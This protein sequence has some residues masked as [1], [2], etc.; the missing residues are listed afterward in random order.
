MRYRLRDIPALL[1]SPIGRTQLRGSI[2]MT[3]WPA[4]SLLAILYR[5]TFARHT[6]VVVVVGSFGKTTTTRALTTIL[7]ATPWRAGSNALSSVAAGL[8]RIHPRDR[9]AVIEIGIEKPGEMA[10]YTRMVRPDIT[11]VTSIGSEHNSSLGRLE[12]TRE[13]K[14]AM[15]RILP[16]SGLAVLNGDDPNVLWM[17]GQTQARVVTFG[18][19]ETN[20]V[21]AGNLSLEGWPNG[22][23]FTL[24]ADGET[25]DLHIRLI[26]RP[27]VYAILAAVAVARAEGFTLDQIQPGLEALTPTPG[28]LEPFRLPNGAM[29]LGD[30]FKSALET[31]EAALDVLAELPA[32]RRI[33]VLGQVTEPPGKSGDV[34]RH[35]GK[36]IGSMAAQAI[37][38][39]GKSNTA[40]SAGATAAGMP[41]SAIVKAGR[42]IFKAIEALQG[43][44]GPGDG[45]LI[46]GRMT[47]R[48][49][50]ITL[51][52]AGRTVNCRIDYCKTKMIRCDECP[53]LEKG[54]GRSEP[55][56]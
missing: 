11:V 51:A 20:D 14:A 26:G 52:L 56:I 38:I 7:C 55:V 50:R 23:R 22:T 29:I 6:R 49:G 33:V 21:R 2:F 12:T 31:V 25:R 41:R 15:V 4:L 30:D 36:R 37:F 54:W 53:M 24:H 27:M 13:E 1:R 17:R 44:L 34:Y 46:K 5:R 40:C 16:P 39:C 10:P 3:L 9:H 18:F 43:T 28:R 19:G 45:V 48:L 35:L 47:E 42:D 32:K 8:F